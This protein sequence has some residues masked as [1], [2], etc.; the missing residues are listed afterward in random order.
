MLK[1]LKKIA[2]FLLV[3]FAFLLMIYIFLTNNHYDR[4]IFLS[5]ESATKNWGVKA[6]K[7]FY[8]YLDENLYIQFDSNKNIKSV[9]KE[10]F[11]WL[12]NNL[13]GFPNNNEYNRIYLTTVNDTVYIFG[14]SKYKDVKEIKLVDA[15]SNDKKLEFSGKYIIDIDALCFCAKIPVKSLIMSYK[16][17]FVDQSDNVIED[18]LQNLSKNLQTH[19]T[20]ILKDISSNKYEQ[21]VN[22]NLELTQLKSS[23]N[24]VEKSFYLQRNGKEFQ[25]HKISRNIDIYFLSDYALIVDEKEIFQSKLKN[26]LKTLYTTTY[27]APYDENLNDL[28]MVS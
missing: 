10:A 13:D 4:K 25:V 12:R 21:I 22:E 20:P 15:N 8:E 26:A 16:I 3:F 18:S 24:E 14:V 17:V 7:V 11:L 19:I 6:D 2:V 5:N 28:R 27:R 23:K 1:S 9:K